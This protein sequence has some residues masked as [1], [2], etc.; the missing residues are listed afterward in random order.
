[1]G[2]QEGVS[3]V[4]KQEDVSIMSIALKQSRQQVVK[5]KQARVNVCP[6]MFR[7]VARNAATR[8]G[9]THQDNWLL[10]A[11]AASKGHMAANA[12]SVAFKSTPPSDMGLLRR[13]QPNREENHYP[14]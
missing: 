12:H 5:Y 7:P 11:A 6:L 9:H 10:R 3:V 8:W 4:S 13:W 2:K 14:P 1:M